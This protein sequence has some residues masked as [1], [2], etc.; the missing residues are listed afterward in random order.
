MSVLFLIASVAFF[1]W[2]I[3]NIFFWVG[4][5]QVK[6]Y[7]F[8]RMF[9]H[10]AE[11]HQGRDILLSWMLFLKILVI[12]LFPFAVLLPEYMRP[13]QA[14]ITC[15][16]CLQLMLFLKEIALRKVKRP[17]L[18]AK[19]LFLIA[20]S[21]AFSLLLFFLPVI[22]Y[23]LWLLIIDRLLVFFIAFL[24]AIL[25]V[26]TEFYRDIKVQRAI[27]KLSRYK[28]IL[29]IGITGSYGKSTTKEYLAQILEKKF[30]VVK[31]KGTNNTPIGIAQTILQSIKSTTEIFVVEMG[32]YK[33]GEIK[34]LCNIVYPKIGVLTG[35]NEQ[36]M[37]LFGSIEETTEAKYELIR[38]LPKNGLALFNG[39]NKIVAGLFRKSTKDK[40]LYYT[41]YASKRSIHSVKKSIIASNIKIAKTSLSFSVTI[42]KKILHLEA[43][44]VGV[45]N[46]EG[47][48]PAIYIAY[49]LGMS[50]AEI[51]NAVA[52]LQS[53]PQ[54]MTTVHGPNGS[55]ILDDTYN[56]NPD[57]V[58]S[59]FRY[60]TLY[61]GRKLLVLQPM[62]ELG[63]DAGQQHY[64][65]GQQISK[66]YDYLFL[67][68]KNFSKEIIKGIEDGGGAC[69]VHIENF[70]D[71]ASFITKTAKK[72]DIVVLEGREAGI[73]Y[74][75]II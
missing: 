33:K 5:W 17:V 70:D 53:L 49:H 9:A 48:L 62:I 58:L 14:F 19:A 1:V 40:V 46:I 34:E 20:C 15:V 23:F 3:R 57:A 24:V 63:K 35:I 54:T 25:G 13:Y 31:T 27:K 68:N 12:L 74:K 21:L 10:L 65:L 30:S 47:I 45:Q 50:G 72:G 16:F 6:E 69:S 51:K 42:A 28:N 59:T 56:A 22:E 64:E 2:T 41:T 7:R 75:K 18:T 36:H 71:C 55:T 60:V 52:K 4:L 37:S 66:V 32:A 67:T 39:N 43:P 44:L 29:V 61:R 38:S 11:T 26:P 8:D 73:I